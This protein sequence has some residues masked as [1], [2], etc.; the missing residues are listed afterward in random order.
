[1]KFIEKTGI[2][3]LVALILSVIIFFNNYDAGAG[4]LE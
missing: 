3:V 2:V 4:D 1:V